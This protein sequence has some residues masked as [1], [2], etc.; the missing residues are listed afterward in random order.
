[1]LPHGYLFTEPSFNMAKP[2]GG[3]S[4]SF[5]VL[6]DAVMVARRANKYLSEKH[7]LST[8][9]AGVEYDVEQQNVA[10]MVAHGWT[11]FIESDAITPPPLPGALK[12]NP[13][14]S[15]VAGVRRVAAG[16][17][18]L[19][20]WLGSGGKPVD[21]ALAEQR[22]SICA[23]CPKNWKGNLS[24]YFIGKAAQTIKTQLEMKNDLSLKTSRDAELGVCEACSCSLPLKVQA[25]LAHIL[26]HT[27]ADVK[28][29]LHPLCWILHEK[30]S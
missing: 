6:V 9:R 8:D 1:M 2:F 23:T 5:R 11:D 10:R 14:G 15:V 25:P 19:L 29:R 17:G 22:A 30:A 13:F 16:V 18:V 28:A 20:D 12:K 3:P 4:T 24:D 27:S 21:Q 26:A 7:N